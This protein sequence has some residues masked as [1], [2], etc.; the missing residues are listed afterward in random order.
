MRVVVLGEGAR[1]L[2]IGDRPVR[3]CADCARGA[4]HR[5]LVPWT[6]DSLASA[7]SIDRRHG[8]VLVG[9]RPH[10]SFG[11]DPVGQDWKKALHKSV[12]RRVGSAP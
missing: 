8:C 10:R 9:E 1:G 12:D 5:E 6:N 2:G 11:A 7:C 3:A 4:G